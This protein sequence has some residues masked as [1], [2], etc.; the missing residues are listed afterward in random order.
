MDNKEFIIDIVK[1]NW[2]AII[3]VI[4]AITSIIVSGLYVYYKIDDRSSEIS[5]KEDEIVLDDSTLEEEKNYVEVD[6]KGAVKKPGVYT[7][8]EGSNI[9]NAIALAGGIT[10]KATTENVNLSKKL[11]DEMVV[12]IFTKE[13]LKKSLDSNKLTCEI[14]K[15]ECET[16][17]V[18]NCVDDKKEEVQKDDKISLNRASIEELSSLDGIGES[19]AKAIVEYRTQNGDFKTIDEVKNVSGIG[20]L[21]F[22]KIKDKI[23]I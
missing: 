3:S 16:I 10:T 23:T 15:C 18:D 8:L 12:Y 4:I 7:L 17:K 21:L 6:V 1:K 2:L 14:P 19:K 13:E 11:K 22:D 20:D 9:S 5:S